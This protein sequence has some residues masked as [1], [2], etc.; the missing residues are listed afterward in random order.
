MRAAT[1]ALDRDLP[2]RTRQLTD[3]TTSQVWGGCVGEGGRCIYDSDCCPQQHYSG[4][5]SSYLRCIRTS[6]HMRLCLFG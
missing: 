1:I 2:A 3:D 6:G 5:G 4:S